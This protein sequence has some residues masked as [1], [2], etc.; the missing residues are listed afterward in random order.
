MMSATPAP[1]RPWARS[2]A[3]EGGYNH[4]MKNALFFG[5]LPRSTLERLFPPPTY[6]MPTDLWF[7][8]SGVLQFVIAVWAAYYLVE[9]WRD[10]RSGAD[11]GEG[12]NDVIREGS[13]HPQARLATSRPPQDR[14]PR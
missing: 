13:S 7:E 8:G 5:G 9:L 3:A 10:T 6:E 1:V 12:L 2:A 11:D 14:Q 4:V